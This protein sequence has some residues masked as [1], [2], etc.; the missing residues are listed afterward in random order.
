MEN[1]SRK[2][3]RRRQPAKKYSI[4]PFEGLDIPDDLTDDR[5]PSAPARDDEDGDDADFQADANP[6]PEP[7]DD[8]D[9]F[10]DRTI[11]RDDFEDADDDPDDDFDYDESVVG[12][13]DPQT[14]RFLAKPARQKRDFGRTKG[15]RADPKYQPRGLLEP[16]TRGSKEVHRL[17]HFGPAQEDQNPALQAHFKWST[18]PT[19]PSRKPSLGGFGGFKRSFY[20]TED[21]FQREANEGWDWFELEGGKEAFRTRQTSSDLLPDDA[22]EYMPSTANTRKFV[23]GPYKQQKL[24]QLPVGA[25]VDL[26]DAWMRE[27]TTANTADTRP[28]IKVA[29]RGWMLNLGEGMHC[30]EWVPNREGPRQ[31]M[32]VSCLSLLDY[33]AGE[34]RFEA[35]SAPAFTPQKPHKSSIQIWEFAVDDNGSIDLRQPPRLR[36]VICTLWGDISFLK[37]CPMPRSQASFSNGDD[38]LNLGLIGGI[39]GDGLVRVLDISIPSLP[40]ADVQYTLVTGTAFS[41]RPPDTLCTCFTWLSP[42]SIAAGCANGS[43]G[44]WNLASAVHESPLTHTRPGSTNDYSTEPVHNAEPVVYFSASSTYILD[45]ISCYPSRPHIIAS[46]SMAGYIYMTDLM[47]MS[48]S[49][50]YS[51]PAT[52]RSSRSR[53]GRATLTWHDW[54]Q[55]ILTG[56]ENFALVAIPLRRIWRQHSFTRYRSSAQAIAASPCHPFVMAGGVGGDVTCINPLRRLYENKSPIWNQIWFTHE[57]RQ[58]RDDELDREP[59]EDTDTVMEGSATTQG[60]AASPRGAAATRRSGLSRIVESY[61]CEQVRLFNAHDTFVNRDNGALYSTIYEVETSVRAVSWNPNVHVGGW[62]AAGMASG[63]LRV[64]DIAA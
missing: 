6:S 26:N 56:D 4:D 11:P 64:E 14:R 30:I 13:A 37:W 44:V 17:F 23:M 39:W 52:V 10:D 48:A 60:P 5:T 20:H 55:T 38:Q 54:S 49:T 34:K 7:L 9:I 51:A 47:D 43:V 21:A 58:L 2:S 33:A 18:E 16:F 46:S 1:K 40:D 57:W 32:A 12:D 63:L 3:G 35:R 8:D 50:A 45:I 53:M 59:V 36:Q 25:S 31:F 42:N 61:R 27:P 24:F 62:V 29:R 22:K 15:A 19:L 41:T 28:D